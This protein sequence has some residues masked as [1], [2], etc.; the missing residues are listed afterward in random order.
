MLVTNLQTAYDRRVSD[1]LRQLEAL[2]SVKLFAGVPLRVLAPLAEQC[3]ERR[4]P[5]GRALFNEGDPGQGLYVLLKGSVSLDHT[6]PRGETLH[7]AVL[8]AGETLGEL[9]L[10]DG[11]V[12]SVTATALEPCVA[13]T[14]SREAFLHAAGQS[15]DLCVAVMQGLGTRVREATIRM[16][17]RQS[18]DVLHRVAAELARAPA[19]ADGVVDLGLDQ[20]ALSQRVGATRESVNRA[21]ARLKR[22]GVARRVGPR[23]YKVEPKRLSRYLRPPP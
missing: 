6:L 19:D 8:G 9:A 4:Y 18:R 17:Q 1:D 20:T 12:R 22:E 7:V 2:R 5:A 11:G 13:L 21:L 3:V 16:G 14:L 15:F 10:L 23:A